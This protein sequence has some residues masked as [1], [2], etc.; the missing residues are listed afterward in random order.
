LAVIA[1]NFSTPVA[2]GSTLGAAGTASEWTELQGGNARSGFNSTQTTLIASTAPALHLRWSFNAGSAISGEPVAANGLI[3]FGARDGNARAVNQ[4]G[5]LVWTTFV[6]ATSIFCE[7]A[8]T[9]VGVGGT[10]AVSAGTGSML[11]VGGGDGWLYGLDAITGAV[12]WRTQLAILPGGFLWS[13]PVVYNGSVYE[14]L[15]SFGDCPLV[16]GALVRLNAATGAI[17][18]VRWMAPAGCL[19]ATIWSSPA[20]D[21]VRGIVYVTTGNAGECGSPEFAS[22][23][24]VAFRASDLGFM[25]LWQVPASALPNTDSDFGATPTLFSATINGLQR[26]LIG[27]ANKNGVYYVLDRTNL[28]AGPIWQQIISGSGFDPTKGE[29]SISPSA[30]D[31][32]SLYVGGGTISM[33][34]VLCGGTLRSLDA[35][36]GQMHWYVCTAAPILAPVSAT[37]GLVI[38][39]A[40]SGLGVIASGTPR[41]LFLFKDPKPGLFWGGTSISEGILYAGSTDGSVYTFSI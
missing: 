34:G 15:A 40:G 33:N 23:A 7:G 27:A 8:T 4:S 32:S 14:G 30:F 35:A 22:T 5:S 10:P 13:S 18:N 25:G 29:G 24:I 2:L 11:Y 41:A 1:V 20:I 17:Q 9:T 39:S 6:G 36:T 26:D 38:A 12:V 31:G 21:E 28:G 19:G 37:A 16:R 3:Y